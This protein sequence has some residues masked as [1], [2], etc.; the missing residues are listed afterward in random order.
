MNRKKLSGQ[1]IWIIILAILLLLTICFGGVFAYYSARS[2]SISGKIVMANLNIELVSSD[3]STGS[4]KS[5]IVISHG[6]N[7]VPNQQ[8]ENTPLIV[9]NKS[10]VSI[11]LIVVYEVKAY[12]EDSSAIPDQLTNSVIDVGANYLNPKK[13]DTK[14]MTRTTDWV[15][16][17]FTG[18]NSS[19]IE[20]NYRCLISLAT[21]DQEQEITVIKENTLRLSKEMGN[22]YQKATI[23]FTFQAYAI[24]STTFNADITPTTSVEDKC[25]IIVSAI[26]KSQGKKF[27]NIN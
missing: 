2:A 13:E 25:S 5:E 15:D 16:Y 26:Y 23:S 6:T 10:S 12:N 19:N 27:L 7:V 9:K 20:E 3:D 4:G 11:Y 8:L 22:E 17:V 14:L 21:Y 1:T 18:L 24:G